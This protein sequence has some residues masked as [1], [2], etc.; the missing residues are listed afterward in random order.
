M[1]TPAR[2]RSQRCLLATAICLFALLPSRQS[3]AQSDPTL[4]SPRRKAGRELFREVIEI[5][6]TA[7]IGSTRA[8][9]AMAARLRQA[10]FAP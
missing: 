4:G 10:G 3:P 7:N 2:S 5:N 6:T 9:E 1:N 8:A